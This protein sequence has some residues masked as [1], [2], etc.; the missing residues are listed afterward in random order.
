MGVVSRGLADE[1]EWGI[2]RGGK[3]IEGYGCLFIFGMG[4]FAYPEVFCRA[5]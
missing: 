1:G 2:V 4:D 5:E 3:G